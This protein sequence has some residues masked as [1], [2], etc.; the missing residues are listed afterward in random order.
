MTFDRS[1]LEID[2]AEE[3]DRIV[4][5]L[6]R[7]VRKTLRRRGAVLG[8]SGG[9]DSSVVLA[10]CVQAFGAERVVP[11]MLPEQD[12]EGDS[13]R[14]AQEVASQ[15][16]VEPIV[17]D[18]TPILEGFRCYERRDEA[19]RRAFPEYDEGYQ[20]KLV[21]P[22]VEERDT[23]NVYSLTIIAPDGEE[24]SK[25]LDPDTF[26]QIMAASN[27]KQRARM[28]L[29]YYH[30]EKRHY[31]VIGTA[32][33]DEHGQGFFVKYGDG[34]VDIQPISH[35]FK[36]Q[37]YQLAEHLD[38]PEEV[39]CRPSTSD[40]YSATQTQEEFFFRL[41]FETL[42]LIWYAKEHDVPVEKVAHVL[43]MEEPEV[44]RMFDDIAR[45]R[46]T[47]EYLRTPPLSANRGQAS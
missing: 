7:G 17:E 13:T 12:S 29:L 6:Q 16:G 38:V 15:Y 40:T 31:A 46:R 25:R 19:I 45:K 4:S 41:P 20:A 3:V 39:L 43:D 33:K 21:L 8:I 47:T 28:A 37:V 30:A 24:K 1:V 2:P 9:V 23:L 32:N 22:Q 42:D 27:V 36:T 14:L 35:L 26:L 5:Q 34:G 10:L 44:Q 11:L 18:I